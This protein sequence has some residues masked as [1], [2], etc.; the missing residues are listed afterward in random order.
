MWMLETLRQQALELLMQAQQ[1]LLVLT[2]EKT[3]EQVKAVRLE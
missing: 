2:P 1:A 3:Q